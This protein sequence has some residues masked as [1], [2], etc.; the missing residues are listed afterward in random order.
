MSS[1]NES[2]KRALSGEC[3]IPIIGVV[4]SAYYVFSAR[5]MA[6]EARS[7]SLF[8]ALVVLFLSVVVVTKS[9]WRRKK[10]DA[11]KMDGCEESG[12]KQTG[13]IAGRNTILAVLIIIAT[14]VYVMLMVHVGVI[15][16]TLGY[17]FLM[18]AVQNVIKGTPG[19][20]SLLRAIVYSVL[21]ALVLYAVFGLILE[22]EL[23]GWFLEHL[24]AG[25]K[26]GVMK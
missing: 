8:I 13:V 16:S 17:V 26:R 11:D 4:Y 14:I 9:V 22:M 25:L 12:V 19:S 7:Y 20:I 3:L 1:E 18:I 23:P 6:W 5:G 21:F 24:F 10:G 15:L 2:G